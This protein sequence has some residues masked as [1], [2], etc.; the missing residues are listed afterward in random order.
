M[1]LVRG[2]NVYP[3]AVE[4]VLRAIPGVAEYQVLITGRGGPGAD[5]HLRIE[6]VPGA[7]GDALLAEVREAFHSA[8]F[9]R[10]D[11]ELSP[12]GSLPRFEMKARRFSFEGEKGA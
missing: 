9:F 1:V 7:G 11:V 6:A 4:A 2:N 8:L 12:P 5:L 3:S 10:P